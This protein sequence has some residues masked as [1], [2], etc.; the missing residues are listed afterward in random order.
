MPRIRMGGSIDSA[1]GACGAG[2]WRTSGSLRHRYTP[3][4]A[5]KRASHG[6]AAR[7]GAVRRRAICTL[8]PRSDATA[9]LVRYAERT[10]PLN[11]ASNRRRP[12]SWTTASVSDITRRAETDDDSTVAS[13]SG[14][15]STS[16]SRSIVIVSVGSPPA[17]DCS[18]CTT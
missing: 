10:S 14:R 15:R 9:M 1:G 17:T 7:P 13:S 3:A 8:E 18:T 11:V 5:S 4:S 12:T 16:S 6:R 2:T